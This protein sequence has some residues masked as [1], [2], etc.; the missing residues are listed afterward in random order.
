MK[1]KF[2]RSKTAFPNHARLKW[3]FWFLC[4]NWK[5]SINVT[6]NALK[7]FNFPCITSKMQR[8]Q[9]QKKNWQ[10]A[11][12]SAMQWRALQRFSLSPVTRC[13]DFHWRSILCRFSLAPPTQRQ[14][15]AMIFSGVRHAADSPLAPHLADLNQKFSAAPNSLNCSSHLW[16]TILIQC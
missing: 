8:K 12:A 9:L 14:C 3:L 16:R 10:Y 11:N 6:N 1:K 2:T 15:N 7:M 5:T 13:S 4:K